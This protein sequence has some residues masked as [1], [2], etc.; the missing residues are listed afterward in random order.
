MVKKH[1][2]VLFPLFGGFYAFALFSGSFFTACQSQSQNQSQAQVI[3]APAPEPIP[4]PEVVYD[5]RD[6]E[7]EE[8]NG[9]IAII[10]YTGTATD[11]TI[12]GRINNLPVTLIRPRAFYRK[13]LTSISIPNGVISIE[14]AAFSN[15]KLSG[16][17]IPKSVTTIGDLAF[18]VNQLSSITIPDTVTS[19]GAYAFRT[20]KLSSIT[21]PNSI[22]S[23]GSFTFAD[24]Q[25]TVITIP[26]SVTS[27]G[28]MA[29]DANRLTSITIGDGKRYAAGYLGNDFL[30]NGYGFDSAYEENNRK[31]G[32]YVYSRSTGTW[33]L[34]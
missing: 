22:T 8:R 30:G 12:P 28:A 19:I 26:D 25:L 4:E 29:F 14:Y 3:T 31:G 7:I 1:M 17:T 2:P 15:N 27:I 18:S 9:G 34:R 13:S 11:V 33:Q 20:N 5:S 21:I 10:A 6:F 23:I 24:N 16:I 32:T